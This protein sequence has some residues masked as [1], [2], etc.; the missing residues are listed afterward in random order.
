LLSRLR[1]DH[2]RFS[3]FITQRVDKD[4]VGGP[5]AC[6]DVL[7]V[8]VIVNAVASGLLKVSLEPIHLPQA[9]QIE[10]EQGFL[11]TSVIRQLALAIVDVRRLGAA[12][13]SESVAEG[14]DQ[15]RSFRVSIRRGC[16]KMGLAPS[17]RGENPGKSAVSKVPVPISSQPRNVAQDIRQLFR[18]V[19]NEFAVQDN[20]PPFVADRRPRFPPRDELHS[21]AVTE[22]VFGFCDLC[23]TA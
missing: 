2:V 23:A 3:G 5:R 6:H 15:R 14:L 21:Q 4:V 17:R 16:E 9:C 8:P 20:S 13:I 12:V 18:E 1:S 7:Q 11:S 19:K 22:Q 10:I